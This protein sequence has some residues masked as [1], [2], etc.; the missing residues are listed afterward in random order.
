M[1]KLPL[2]GVTVALSS[3][4][5]IGFQATLF[6]TIGRAIGPVRASL[7]LNVTG[8]ILAGL[9]LLGVIGFQ[10]HAQWHIPRSTLISATIAVGMGIGIVIGVAFSFQQTGVAAGVATLFLGQVLVGIFVDTMG[11][12]GGDPIPLEPRRL[13]GLLV[14][15]MAI[16]LLV[17]ET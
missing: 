4:L 5:A 2:I 8:G 15:V 7:I 12:S 16:F 11:W 6:T 17:R 9:I 10:G 14:M 3:G 13:L 1:E